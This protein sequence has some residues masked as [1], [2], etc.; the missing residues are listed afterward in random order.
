[1]SVPQPRF[2]ATYNSLTD[3][4]LVGYFSNAR[5]RRHLQKSGLISRSGRIIPEKEYRLNAMRKD[6]QRYVQECLARAIFHKVLDM[7]RHHQLEIKQTLEYSTKKEKVQKVKE[8][9]C[10]EKSAMRSWLLLRAS[11]K[12]CQV[13]QFR[14]SVEDAIP[15]H[16]PHPPL[17]PRNRS[18]L[19]PLVAG[20]RAGRS[21]W[22]VPGL[23]ADYGGRH[24]AHQRRPKEPAPSKVSSWHPNTAP[25]NVQLPLHLR[26]LRGQAAAG[27]VPK[28]ARQ[29]G[30]TLEWDQQF[31]QGLPVVSPR[32]VPVPPP[33]LHRG[34]RAV[35]AGRSG[36][37]SARRLRPTTAS[38]DTGQLLTKNSGGFPKSPL[39]SNT[40]VTMVYLGKNVHLSHDNGD[41]R[42][43][44]KVY[45][46]HCGGENLC[47]YKG[48][49]LEGETFQFT[50]RRHHGFPFSLTFFLNG[51]QVER[52]SCCC[53]YKHQRRSR[54]QGRHRYF[55]FLSVEG[56]SPCY[57]CIIAMGLDKK[58]PP[59]KRKIEYRVDKHVG[60][61]EYA[62]HSEPS[63]SSVEQKSVKNSVLVI[64]PGHEAS[65]ETLEEKLETGEEYREEEMTNQSS[66]ESEDS[67][68]DISKNE[69]DEDFEADEEVNEEGQAADQTNGM[70]ESSLDDK[71]HNL[72]YGKESGI[73]A[74]HISGSKKDESD[75]YSDRDSENNQQERK[76][77]DSFSS[78]S[79][80][81]ST[82]GDSHS[83]M[84][85]DSGKE[86]CDTKRVS[87]NTAHA[88]YGNRNREKKL[89]RMEENWK[90]SALKKKGLDEAREAKP[91]DL[92]AREDNGFFNGNIMAMQHQSP[93][94]NGELKQAG[95]GESNTNDEEEHLPVPWESRIL[96]GEN[97]N[98][99][100]PQSEEGSVFED[101]KPVQQEMAKVTGNY[102]PVNS[103]P[104]P[105]DCHASEETENTANTEHD[106][107]GAPD[108][109]FSAEGRRSHDVQ[110]AAGKEVREGQ[111]V[112]QSQAPEQ[113][114]AAT[115]GGAGSEEPGEAA[116]ARD[117]LLQAGTG[118]ELEES[119][120]EEGTVAEEHL[121]GEG[122]RDRVE[123]STEVSPGG[124]E[125]LVEE[126]EN[127]VALGEPAL[128]E[129]GSAGALSCPEAD[130]AVSEGQ[131]GAVRGT[132]EEE[133]AE[134]GPEG[135]AGLQAEGEL[136]EAVSET[137]ESLRAGGSAGKGAGVDAVAE[138][139]KAVEDADL[140]GEG[141]VGVVGPDREV[142]VEEDSSEWEEAVGKAGALLEALGD[143]ET[144]EA[145]PGVEGFVKPNEF[146][147]L[148]ESGEEQIEIGKAAAGTAGAERGQ[149][150]T[151]GGNALWRA[152]DMVEVPGEP[153]KGPVQEGV[154]GLGAVGATGEDPVNEGSYQVEETPAVQEEDG[155]AET[156]WSGNSSVGSKA[157]SQRAVEGEANGG[158]AGGSA[159]A[160]AQGAGGGEEAADGAAGPR[161]AAAGMEGGLRCGEQRGKGSPSGE[162]EVGE[163]AA[164]ALGTGRAG[165]PGLGTGR[166]GEPGLGTGR[167]GEPGLGTG[168]AGEPGLVAI[169]VRGGPEG[170]G[171][172]AQEPG[173]AATGAVAQERMTV[174]VLGAQGGTGT[175]AAEEVA[176]EGRGAT[177]EP[178]RNRIGVADGAVVGGRG[179]SQEAALRGEER[180]PEPARAEAER[181]WGTVSPRHGGAV[182]LGEQPTAENTPARGHGGAEPSGTAAAGGE[183]LSPGTPTQRAGK[184]GRQEGTEQ[185]AV[186][187]E[188]EQ[189]GPRENTTES[190]VVGVSASAGSAAGAGQQGKDGPLG[191]SP[192]AADVGEESHSPCQDSANSD[193]VIVSAEQPQDEEETLL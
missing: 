162:G 72:D 178:G 59:P 98:K 143:I 60:S 90:T 107:S 61:W 190:E 71:K 95:S 89:L 5:I 8:P 149:V 46:Q 154:T 57:R 119:T 96:N 144:G 127:K 23:E 164:P 58:L 3:K 42:D 146:S 51:M 53:E 169:A 128:V 102:H 163:A 161:E 126:T 19:H 82:E 106:A 9:E 63:N 1:M 92:T 85:T 86:E 78:F 33:R 37:H 145:V 65:V 91:E 120:P 171:A 15:M 187:A 183:G 156:L 151:V 140:A 12:Q 177:P 10:F 35:P 113:D 193:P 66:N 25:G 97:G 101:C 64:V 123:S 93:E 186:K 115:G 142:A 131:E 173:G 185:T 189:S 182:S 155:A 99:E 175:A 41:Y 165:E 132:E 109:S 124:Q 36:G 134:K 176:A 21:Q 122:T 104:E 16:S 181:E 28:A 138:G 76:P 75:R 56:A 69:Y 62:M 133:A 52:L 55:R 39:C 67:Q 83:E 159:E 17:G 18:G 7:E 110:E 184:D 77:A 27:A 137:G 32:V 192:G 94:V 45:Q 111:V 174:A 180:G 100:C 29:K 80:Q 147:Q 22:R 136:G 125:G 112:G 118:A 30:H 167:A 150:W 188:R 49:L 31:A 74:L 139:E 26:P 81:C 153:G 54:L 129:E 44:I 50:S 105:G 6:H 87:A 88:Q 38:N 103:D 170:R 121:K 179:L 48:K 43:E 79:T 117:L 172:L 14:R 114:S 168:R 11:G 166:A 20:E 152:E 116:R 2:L 157:E 141:I 68:E 84:M 13:E 73:K 34:D 40:V 130:R 70:S 108:G 158:A 191:G 135:A 24:P 160:A 47:V 148:K 4:H